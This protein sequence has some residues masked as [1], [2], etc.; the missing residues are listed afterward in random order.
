M[1]FNDFSNYM[2]GNGVGNNGG[3]MNYFSDKCH[4]KI[5]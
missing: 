3:K 4:A 2:A 5:Y 1:P